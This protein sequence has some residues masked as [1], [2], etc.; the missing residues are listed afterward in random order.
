MLREAVVGAPID[1]TILVDLEKC[2]LLAL[3]GRMDVVL[4][5]RS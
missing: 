2:L 5:C 4:V 3:A 1:D